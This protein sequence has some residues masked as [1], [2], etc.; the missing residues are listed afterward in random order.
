MS[1][2]A[3]AASLVALARELKLDLFSLQRQEAGLAALLGLVAELL[4]KH[5]D[6]ATV[7]ACLRTLL[8][9]ATSGPDTLQVLGPEVATTVA[10]LKEQE[11]KGSAEDPSS[12]EGMFLCIL[13]VM[14][15]SSAT[16]SAD[17][18]LS[19]LYASFIEPFG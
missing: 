7:D 3:Q 15:R 4:F 14:R 6:A 12:A 2:S 16:Y 17:P 18:S 13:Y 1:C 19:S 9:C 8:H 5:A 11:V 10:G